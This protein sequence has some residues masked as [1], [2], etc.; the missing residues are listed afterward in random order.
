ME[1]GSTATTECLPMIEPARFEDLDSLVALLGVLFTQESEMQ[2]DAAKQRAG[3]AAILANPAAGQ[4]FVARNDD[5]AIPGARGEV[6]GMIGLLYTIS[7]ALGG[8]VGVV[9]DFVVRPDFRGRGIGQS[10]MDAVFRHAK[11]RGLLRLTLQTDRDNVAAQRMYE[12]Y[13]FRP[14]TM[15]MMKCHLK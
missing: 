1:P 12:R 15:L 6:V 10:L 11:E 13:G 2:P 9:E 8:P 5:G 14:S 3:L 4:L 7:T